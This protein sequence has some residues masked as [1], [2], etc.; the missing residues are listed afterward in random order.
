MAKNKAT[1]VSLEEEVTN[2]KK[3]FGGIVAT[4]KALME[5]VDNL[6]KLSA[7]K[8]TDEVKDILEKQKAIEK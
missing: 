4:I 5:K 8:E 2:L 6:Q 3:H 7:P 1:K